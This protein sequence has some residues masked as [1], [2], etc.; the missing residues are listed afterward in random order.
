MSQSCASKAP[1]AP[2][3]RLAARPSHAGRW[4]ALVLLLV[5]VAIALHVWHW[6]SSG[7]TLS[8]L[9]PSESMAFS[10]RGI[11]NAGLVFFALTILSTFVLGR[12]FC[13]WAC[14]L[15]AVQDGARW[16]LGRF[17]IRP[18]PL[19][20]GLLGS[21]PWLAFVYMFLSPIV[22]RLLEGAGLAPV[23]TQLVT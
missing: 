18:R 23:G 4:R 19:Q 9:E 15:V 11:V 13:G 6:Y 12:W 1:D 14:H 10:Q 20:L 8:P 22:L 2:H 17:G 21:V 5:H 16:L 3:A 7:R